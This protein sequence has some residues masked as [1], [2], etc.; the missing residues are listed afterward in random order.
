MPRFAG[1]RAS[2]GRSWT[3][4]RSLRERPP[5][6]RSAYDQVILLGRLR[7]AIDRLNPSLSANAREQ[8]LRVVRHLDSPSLVQANRRF[9]RMLVEGVE[10]E[11]RR[12][13]G[14]IAGHRVRLVDFEHP[15]KNDWLAVN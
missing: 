13:D 3:G 7:A 4:R 5:P 14:S 11:D 6:S 15:E 12:A 8:A 1:L 2:A 10:V 9:H